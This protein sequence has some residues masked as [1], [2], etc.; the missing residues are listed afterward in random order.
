[1]PDPAGAAAELLAV[2]R[3]CLDAL[4]AQQ[5]PSALDAVP[6][7]VEAVAIAA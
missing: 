5:H 4:D 1:M 2:I 7:D 3:R 6:E